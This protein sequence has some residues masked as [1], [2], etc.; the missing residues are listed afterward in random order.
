MTRPINEDIFPDSKCRPEVWMDYD[1]LVLLLSESKLS[2]S[3]DR[4]ASKVG[5]S[6]CME[7]HWYNQYDYEGSPL[8]GE[9]SSASGS[10]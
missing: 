3:R 4:C 8:L 1:R 9:N 2:V 5:S 6:N 7:N 10:S